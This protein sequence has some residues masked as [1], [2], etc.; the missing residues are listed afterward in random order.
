MLTVMAAGMYT[1]RQRLNKYIETDTYIDR[2]VEFDTQIKRDMH[3]HTYTHTYT[4]HTYEMAPFCLIQMA[5]CY[6]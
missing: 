6:S 1:D 2:L 5:Q 3:T 4:P